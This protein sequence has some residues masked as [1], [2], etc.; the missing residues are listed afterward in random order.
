M[1]DKRQ[2]FLISTK[3]LPSTI[4]RNLRSESG[5]K[6]MEYFKEEKLPMRP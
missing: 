6:G 2:T 3:R 4:I 5:Q 1:R